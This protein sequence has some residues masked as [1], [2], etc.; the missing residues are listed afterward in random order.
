MTQNVDAYHSQAG[1]KKVLELH[2]RIMENRCFQE[3]KLLNNKELDHNSIPPRCSCGSFVRPGVVWFGES[4]PNDTLAEAFSLARS[5]DICLVIGTAGV[6]QP[7]ASIPVY[8]KNSKAFLI[9]VNNQESALTYLMDVFLEGKAGE[10][11]PKLEELIR[12]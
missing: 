10:I 4:L 11:L 12:H 6:V 7:A 8:A 9:E 1:S 3:V 5:C 2:G